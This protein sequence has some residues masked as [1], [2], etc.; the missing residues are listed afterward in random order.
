MFAFCKP[1]E[2]R[3]T[4]KRTMYCKGRRGRSERR[5]LIPERKFRESGVPG[6]MGLVGFLGMDMM[7]KVE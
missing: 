4:L 5:D 2:D 3:F 6:V 7:T 1:N